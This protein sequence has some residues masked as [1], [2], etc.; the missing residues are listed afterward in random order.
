MGV[1]ERF[2]LTGVGFLFLIISMVDLGYGVVCYCLG[3]SLLRKDSGRV[4]I[5]PL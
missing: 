4:L 1:S 3:S 5:V 2:L